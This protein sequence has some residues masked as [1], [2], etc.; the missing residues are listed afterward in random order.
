MPAFGQTFNCRNY[1]TL[2]TSG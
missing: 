1:A 2:L